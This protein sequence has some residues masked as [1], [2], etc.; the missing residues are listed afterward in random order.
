MGETKDERERDSYGFALSS[1]EKEESSQ[2]FYLF[3]YSDERLSTLRD[4]WNTFF[5]S[6]FNPMEEVFSQKRNKRNEEQLEQ[7]LRLGLPPEIRAEA[8][9]R[10]SGS[11]ELVR[12]NPGVYASY[13]HQADTFGS[14]SANQIERDLGRTFP[15]NTMFEKIEGREKMRRVLMA[16]SVKNTSVGYCQS[17]NFICGMLLLFMEEE[18]AFWTMSQIIE[19]YLPEDYF[20]PTMLSFQIDQKVFSTLLS[21]AYPTIADVIYCH[22]IPMPSDW[23]LC[24]FATSLPTESL[25]RVWD[26]F[27]Y[28][29]E[30]MLFQTALALMKLLSPVIT[31]TK[32]SA[33]IMTRLKSTPVI[34]QQMEAE[35]LRRKAVAKYTS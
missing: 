9:Q 24:L 15:S 16:Y 25:V 29:G 18:E 22:K 17:M 1:W 20:G 27:F 10:L 4:E 14:E 8:W 35:K 28:V 34:V 23:F 7:L 33:K 12:A 31:R 5:S 11:Y 6:F 3:Y 2:R 32:D 13:L 21:L 30:K 19:E 26:M